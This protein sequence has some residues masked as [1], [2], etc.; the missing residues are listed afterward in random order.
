M[1]NLA[2]KIMKYVG[3]PN[4]DHYKRLEWYSN[5]VQICLKNHEQYLG[6]YYIVTRDGCF[7]V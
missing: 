1:V 7:Y 4:H 3:L 5:G 6:A 2:E